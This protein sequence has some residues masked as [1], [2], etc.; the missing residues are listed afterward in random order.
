LN[1]QVLVLLGIFA[2]LCLLFVLFFRKKPKDPSLEP[3]DFFT[4]TK[5]DLP[6]AADAPSQELELQPALK[7]SA[8][9]EKKFE[10]N[11]FSA[12]QEQV[13]V[14]APPPLEAPPTLAP[15][16]PAPWEIALKKSREP[17]LQRLRGTFKE[18]TSGEAWN[19]SHPI[20]ALRC[21]SACWRR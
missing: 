2:L 20:L 18:L 6:P 13:R 16:K 7:K 12:P 14:S 10:E 19:D 5:P 8:A 15:A 17:L 3:S 1:E 4:E 9:P 21:R 11:P